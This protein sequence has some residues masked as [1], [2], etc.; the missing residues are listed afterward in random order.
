MFACRTCKQTQAVGGNA[1]DGAAV[2][3]RH[4]DLIAALRDALQDKC[5]NP[6]CGVIVFDWVNC[7]AV[8]C[9]TC[10][11]DFCGVCMK[12]YIKGDAHTHVRTCTEN[13]EKNYYITEAFMAELRYNRR[14]ARVYAVL[15][16]EPVQARLEV[17]VF[18]AE[19]ALKIRT[20]E[21]EFMMEEEFVKRYLLTAKDMELSSKLRPIVKRCR[22]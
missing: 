8:R 10:K 20:K 4:A 21:T 3:D 6:D 11:H 18:M 1:G 13:R 22:A 5:P 17:A 14:R 15:D 12:Y 9:D 19:D 2:E 16:A 7:A